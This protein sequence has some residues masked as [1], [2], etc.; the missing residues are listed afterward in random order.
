MSDEWLH[1]LFRAFGRPSVPPEGATD[2]DVIDDRLNQIE[3][4]LSDV[5]LRLK[6]LERQAD[7]RGI[8]DTRH[9]R[10]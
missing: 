3:V 4:S 7:P 2:L 8:R 10:P 9:D 5:V 1:R 6:L